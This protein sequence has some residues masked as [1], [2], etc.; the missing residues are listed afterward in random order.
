M[1]TLVK[2]KSL[3]ELGPT[4]RRVISVE[5][6]FMIFKMILLVGLHDY[7]RNN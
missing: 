7:Y 4:L 3:D 1:Y 5:A 6:N 2:V